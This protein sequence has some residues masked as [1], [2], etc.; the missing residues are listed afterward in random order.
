MIFNRLLYEY[1]EK[2]R[3]EK[4]FRIRRRNEEICITGNMFYE[5]CKK[6]ASFLSE[7]T[8]EGS[9]I[10]LLS[11]DGLDMA[12]FLFSVIASGRV[13]VPLN[14]DL[15][16]AE[17]SVCIEASDVSYILFNEDERCV[18]EALRTEKKIKTY[19][20]N[21]ILEVKKCNWRGMDYQFPDVDE[22]SL[23]LL[24]FSSGTTGKGKIVMLSQE[25]LTTNP[26]TTDMLCKRKRIYFPYPCHH[27][28]YVALLLIH[29]GQGDE[30]CLQSSMKYFLQDITYFKPQQI[31]VVPSLFISLSEKA[32]RSQ[33]FYQMLQENLQ[34][35]WSVGA[36]LSFSDDNVINRL[37][38]EIIS[39][40][41]A[42]ETGG[43]VVDYVMHNPNS[44]GP[45]GSYN[46]VR[47]S[48][49]GE[50][51][52]KGKNLMMG[53]YNDVEQTAEVIVN[54][55]FHT[56]D[57]GEI[58]E[59]QELYIKGRSKNTI[60]LSN[61]ENVNPEEIEANLCKCICVDEA[62]VYGKNEK[63]YAVVV[64]KQYLGEKDLSKKKEI[65]ENIEKERKIYN[66]TVPTYRQVRQIKVRE[67]EFV[68]TS[69]GKIKRGKENEE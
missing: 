49:N 7:H 67:K 41:G 34:R 47:L 60:I 59:N 39:S 1:K 68:R 8:E 42:T 61:G 64:N 36:T 33:D 10:G 50:I 4:M 40:Y 28:A 23:S 9:H 32:K 21:D 35:I 31:D 53:Y 19:L 27:I 5:G 17:L 57:I 14:K 13:A 44:V 51:L 3:D 6:F 58:G 52:V 12:F 24:L 55:W 56:G 43:F 38:V 66:Q 30:V 48:E 45:I 18:V 26:L 37:G 54:G 20:M 11:S 2:Y 29:L 62:Y 25:A 46:Q 15:N 16:E 22:K 69:S 63:I 65:L